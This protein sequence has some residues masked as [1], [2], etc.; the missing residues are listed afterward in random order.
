MNYGLV[1]LYLAKFRIINFYCILG[2][3]IVSPGFPLYLRDSHCIPTIPI[4]F[5]DSHRI[6][7]ISVVFPGFPI[8]YTGFGIPGI[9]LF[10][11]GK[12]PSKPVVV[13]LCINLTLTKRVGELILCV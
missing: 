8:N 4:V 1:L 12:I 10:P 3:P 5:P 6:L 9:R 13:F 11:L 2:I 7:R